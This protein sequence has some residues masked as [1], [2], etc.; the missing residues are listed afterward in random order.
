MVESKSKRFESTGSL[1]RGVLRDPVFDRVDIDETGS[2]FGHCEELSVRREAHLSGVGTTGF[3]QRPR[4]PG[5]RAQGS[6]LLYPEAGNVPNTPALDLV[7]DVE[8]IVVDREAD[9]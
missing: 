9:G 4:R 3:A 7:Q 8:H 5:Q 2:L 6:I 1:D